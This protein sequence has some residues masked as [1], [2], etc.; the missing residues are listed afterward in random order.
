MMDS[1]AV[2]PISSFKILQK[3]LAAVQI[4]VH[5]PSIPAAMASLLPTTRR[6]HTAVA[7]TR[8]THTLGTSHYPHRHTQPAAGTRSSD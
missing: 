5:A 2:A 8:A 4:A 3:P 7:L 1:G 6:S